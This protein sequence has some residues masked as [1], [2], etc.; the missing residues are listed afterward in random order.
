MDENARVKNIVELA[1]L[2]GVSAGTVSRAL[3]DSS[4]ISKKTRE[5]IQAIAREHGFRP[6]IMARNLRI[7]RAGAIGVLIPLGH[8][9][10]Q[11]ISDPFFITMLG[12]L[13]DA[14]T[15]RGHDLL[16]SRVIPTSPDWLI[17]VAESGR[18]DGIILIGQS[19]QID[20]IESVAAHYKPMVVWG[21]N[22]GNQ[23]HISVGSDNA[24]GGALAA[25]HLIERGCKSF[26]FM[27]DPIAPEINQRYE[28]VRSV[29]SKAGFA[30]RLT[31]VP[32]HLA[33]EA[34]HPEIVA[35]LR[36][37]AQIPDGIIAAS[38]VI[39][40]SAVR[41]LSELGLSVPDQVKV[42]GYDDLSFAAQ[43][44]PPLTTIRQDL[45]AGAAHLV[46]ALFKRIAGQNTESIVLPPRIT[47][48]GS[49]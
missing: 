33:A 47:V 1:A 43:V 2:A 5:K 38:D 9:K 13:A 23:T 8:D 17:N 30:D 4:L 22:T 20:V 10:G 37:M 7:K 25:A 28:G 44:I 27:G 16:L 24:A 11:H 40:M 48:R 18:V 49:S 46:D 31:I 42:V 12:H 35:N 39:A 32:T 26:A 19:D 34:A 21:A 6:N 15:E 3:A 45:V 29:L 36:A 41:A 14:L